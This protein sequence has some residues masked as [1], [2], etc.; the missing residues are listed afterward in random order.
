MSPNSCLYSGSEEQGSAQRSQSIRELMTAPDGTRGT[1][2]FFDVRVDSIGRQEGFDVQS[3]G[4]LSV[5]F[6][7]RGA[8]L[9]L[10]LDP[11]DKECRRSFTY[12]CAGDAMGMVSGSRS[13]YPLFGDRT[14]LF[15]LND[16]TI[17]NPQECFQI[18]PGPCGDEDKARRPDH[19]TRCSQESVRIQAEPYVVMSK[20]ADP[21][22]RLAVR[23]GLSGSRRSRMGRRTLLD[24]EWNF[25]EKLGRSPAHRRCAGYSSS[26]MVSFLGRSWRIL[27]LC[28]LCILLSR[29]KVLARQSR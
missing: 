21:T 16:H 29:C 27:M 7:P 20:Y 24:A 5:G 12:S 9:P 13:V 17:Q 1:I 11:R 10:A 19:T 26:K 18:W 23:R 8:A 3:R 28:C 2:C 4:N 15:P 6:A 14:T 22:V 25:P